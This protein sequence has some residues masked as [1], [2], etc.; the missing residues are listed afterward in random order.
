MPNRK[1]G[2]AKIKS[3]NRRICV[4]ATTINDI[5]ASAFASDEGSKVWFK[6]VRSSL[7]ASRTCLKVSLSNWR[8]ALKVSPSPARGA[9]LAFASKSGYPN[10]A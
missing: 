7:T 5:S 9:E 3:I 8:I 2:C 6:S 10:F 4:R 1:S